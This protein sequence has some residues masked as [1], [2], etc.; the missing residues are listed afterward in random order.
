MKHIAKPFCTLAL[1]GTLPF[2]SAAGIPTK[3]STHQLY[4]NGIRI[5][6]TGWLI[7]GNNYFK[8]RDIGKLV[9]F[10]V[11]YDSKMNA[12]QIETSAGY[13]PESTET[14]AAKNTVHAE[15]VA[16]PTPQIESYHA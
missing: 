2:A 3:P 11:T 4:V 10:S 12:I 7:N 5:N 15:E 16:S 13:I 8:L 6:T 1:L 9:N 14:G